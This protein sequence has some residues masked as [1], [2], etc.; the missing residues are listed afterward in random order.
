[1]VQVQ[2]MAQVQ[3]ASTSQWYDLIRVIIASNSLD[4]PAF[5]PP[6]F[7]LADPEWA[8]SMLILSELRV[9]WSWVSWEY[10]ADSSLCRELA[11]T[12]SLLHWNTRQHCRD[13]WLWQQWATVGQPTQAEL[14]ASIVLG[15]LGGSYSTVGGG[16]HEEANDNHCPTAMRRLSGQFEMNTRLYLLAQLHYCH[17]NCQQ[18]AGRPTSSCWGR[19]SKSNLRCW[20]RGLNVLTTYCITQ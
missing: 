11:L 5:K 7:D 20:S 14:W 9:C 17:R 12:S 18:A 19:L 1:M 15:Q 16:S 8:E 2:A 4:I 13:P 3:E 6:L 10:A